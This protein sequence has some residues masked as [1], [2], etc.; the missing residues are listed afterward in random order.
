MEEDS[1]PGVAPLC[2]YAY[3]VMLRGTKRPFHSLVPHGN[4]C[5][6]MSHASAIFTMQARKDMKRGGL[7]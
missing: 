5:N 6:A 3:V 2:S 4:H 1:V 7:T